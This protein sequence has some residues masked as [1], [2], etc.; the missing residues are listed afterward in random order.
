MRVLIPDGLQRNIIAAIDSMTKNGIT[1]DIAIPTSNIKK[2]NSFLRKVFFT[3]MSRGV[4]KN[5]E[6]PSPFDGVSEYVEAILKIISN[7]PY[8]IVMPFTHGAVAACCHAKDQIETYSKLTFPDFETFLL[9]H[10]KWKT[11]ELCKKTQVPSPRTWKPH[12]Q[13]ELCQL[14]NEISFPA[15]VKIQMGCGIARG[16]RVA[17]KKDEL[18]E[19]YTSLSTQ[20]SFSFLDNFE[21]P[22]IQEF[23]EGPIHDVV[24]LFNDGE[25]LAIMSQKRVLTYP[26]DG[27]TGSVNETT[28]EPRIIEYACRLMKAAGWTGPA[29]CEFKKRGENDYFLL[30]VNPKFWG[31]LDLAISSGLDVPTMTANLFFNGNVK[32]IKEYN[33]GLL[34]RWSLSD[35][36]KSLLQYTSRSKAFLEYI[37]RTFRCNKTSECKFSKPLRSFFTLYST[38]RT[39]RGTDLRKQTLRNKRD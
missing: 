11:Y 13:D 15:V 29:M 4:S 30:E 31:T 25:P 32:P 39:F 23:I 7:E 20:P 24:G 26:I 1:V 12:D 35:E 9:F 5:F 22:I 10:D 6:I 38:L 27:G 16:V 18:M 34:Y 2:G 33:V 8:D 36:I 21:T 14:A 37:Q 28:Y 19:K 17:E 3:T